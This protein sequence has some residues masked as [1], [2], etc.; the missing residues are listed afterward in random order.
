MQWQNIW[1]GPN[2]DAGWGV[3]VDSFGNVYITG[4]YEDYP[5]YWN[6]DVV[7]IKYNQSGLYE[8]N[9]TWGFGGEDI[10]YDIALDSNNNIFIVGVRGYDE[11]LLLKFNSTGDFQWDSRWGQVDDGG[12]GIVIDSSDEIYITGFTQSYG[13][14]GYDIIIMKYDKWGMPLWT[15]RWGE[16]NNEIGND[17]IIDSS[18]N[19][20]ITGYTDSYGAAGEVVLLQYDD[21]GVQLG[22]MSWGGI[23]DDA[24]Y[25][26]ALD[27]LN[28][29]YIVGATLSY[30][31]GQADICLIKNL[32]KEVIVNP[33]AP[34]WSRT[35][36]GDNWDEGTDIAVGASGNISVVGST[37]NTDTGDYNISLV[38]YNNDG[39][40]QW[41]V[42][43]GGIYDDR[44]FGVIMDSAENIYVTGYYSEYSSSYYRDIALIKYNSSGGLVWNKTWGI[45]GEDI[46]YDIA[47]DSNNS[48]YVVGCRGGDMVLVKFNSTGDEQWYETWDRGGIDV[49]YSIY[50]DVLNDIYVVGYTDDISGSGKSDIVLVKYSAGGG[51][52]D[53]E[54]TW[55]G[56]D[57][58]I[59]Y[60]V[61]VDDL[62]GDIY[63][64]GYT[65]SYGAG[66]DDFILLKFDR[67]FNVRW[68]ETWGSSDRDRGYDIDID[69]SGIIYVLGV[70]YSYGAGLADM[71]LVKFNITGTELWYGV[72]GG[73]NNEFGESIF[74]DSDDNV[75]LTGYTSSYG[76]G[77]V[78]MVIVKNL[79]LGGIIAPDLLIGLVILILVIAAIGVVL[80]VLI[81]K[82]KLRFR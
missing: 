8:W 54:D 27:S 44:G 5:G 69:S 15:R 52:P 4:Y 9:I 25:G 16:A 34:E 73:E 38:K 71:C 7:L 58:D 63:V 68:D 51:A 45:G 3:A 39:E 19:L 65:R 82:G 26:L 81:K 18:N 40:Q 57:I 67:A 23:Y 2:N 64:T 33:S 32:K 24:G 79:G 76:N 30:G 43:W 61:V 56:A 72:W 20:Y 12:R 29:I 35:W 55:G 22:N 77:G 31:A 74:I 46:G 21:F 49:G 53:K 48:I 59:G 47:L 62:S 70:T 37:K 10:G 6:R 13:A 1:G 14:E 75:Y 66:N 42:T 78:D 60:S 17:I 11:I 80:V 28:N 50:I 36:G 41:N